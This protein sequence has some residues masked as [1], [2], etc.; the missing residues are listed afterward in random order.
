MKEITK[1]IIEEVKRTIE[2][3]GGTKNLLNKDVVAICEKFCGKDY[4]SR[5]NDEI[6]EI[7]TTISNQIDYFKYSKNM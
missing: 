7:S 5:W 3:V 4:L 6:C 1:Q 2:K